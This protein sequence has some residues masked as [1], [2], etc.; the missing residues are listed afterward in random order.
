MWSSQNVIL[1]IYF[2]IVYIN[3]IILF[4]WSLV[5]YNK[6]LFFIIFSKNKILP[7][8]LLLLHILIYCFPLVIFLLYIIDLPLIMSILTFFIFFL[9]NDK[10]ISFLLT[11]SLAVLLS[12]FECCF[13]YYFLSR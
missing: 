4:F 5:R 7:F 9:K 11:R 12:S 1:H 13:S 10:E 3:F 8:S 2:L 6:Y